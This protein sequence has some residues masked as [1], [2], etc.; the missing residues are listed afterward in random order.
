MLDFCLGHSLQLAE[1]SGRD[2][3]TLR[4]RWSALR[5]QRGNWVGVWKDHGITYRA[6]FDFSRG[7]L[8]AESADLIFSNDCLGYIPVPALEAIMKESSGS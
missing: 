4:A 2:E 8:P 6:P 7:G 1:I 3:T 5:P